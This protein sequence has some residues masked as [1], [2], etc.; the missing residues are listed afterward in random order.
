MG[1]GNNG[2]HKV[3]TKKIPVRLKPKPKIPVRKKSIPVR[4]KKK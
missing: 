3:G 1:C 4:R 2:K